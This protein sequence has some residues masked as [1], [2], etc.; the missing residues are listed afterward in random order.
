[1][2]VLTLAR[3]PQHSFQVAQSL[4]LCLFDALEV[5]AVGVFPERFEEGLGR[6]SFCSELRV[7]H[8]EGD[9]GWVKGYLRT[10]ST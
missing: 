6:G 9:A 1:M 4:I 10:G 7:G 3:R 5:V 8:A 2:T